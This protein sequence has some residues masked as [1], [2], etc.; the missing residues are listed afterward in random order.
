MIKKIRR[1]FV[2]ASMLSLFLVLT[3][4]FS[5]V[6]ILNY[7]NIIKEADTTLQILSYNDGKFPIK[8]DE[9]NEP[10]HSEQPIIN[11]DNKDAPHPLLDDKKLSPELPFESRFFSVLISEDEKILSID[12]QK[13]A[14]I[15]D[16]SA[17][18]MAIKIFKSKKTKG[19][20]NNY[21]F[22]VQKNDEGKLVVFLDCSKKLSS[23]YYFLFVSYFISFIGFSIVF[24]VVVLL[25]GRIIKPLSESYEKQK[26]FITDAGH[27]IKTPITII[28]AD[29]E[30]LECDLP[31]NEWLQDIKLQTARLTTLTNDL[32]YLSKMDE[33][34]S[35]IKIEFP[36]SDV[37]SETTQSFSSLAFSQS[38]EISYNIEKMITIFGDESALRQL[39]SILLDNAVKYS[40]EK[41]TIKVSLAKNGKNIIFIVSNKTGNISEKDIER[42]FDRFYRLDNSRNS[43]TGGHG[44]G[45]SIANAIVNSHKG[46]IQAQIENDNELK[47]TVTLPEK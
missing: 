13:I 36:F 39:V 12:T 1:D 4:I 25:S 26:R 15:D 21:R 29:A 42:I 38:K 46:K 43:S 44:I 11:K 28:D 16:L 10:K 9:P 17:S 7:L 18:Q 22:I 33:N 19:F 37:V 34:K 14:A 40:T 35:H 3:V 23:Y 32:I 20:E 2:L 24:V 8:D 31:E 6:N 27:E 47:I 41:S 45:L 5:T 30:I